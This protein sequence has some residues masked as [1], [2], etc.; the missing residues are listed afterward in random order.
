MRFLIRVSPSMVPRE[1]LYQTVRSVARALGLDPRDPKWTS[2]GALE[3]DVFAPTR[4]DFDLFVSAVEPLATF[5][6]TKDLNFPPP[7]KAEAELLAEARELFNAERYWEC[8]EVL[9]GVWRV[10][11][12]KEKSLLQGLILVCAAFVHSQKGEDNVALGVLRRSVPQL[13]YPG[14]HF[15]GIDLELLRHNVRTMLETSNFTNFTL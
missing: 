5:E 3:L 14:P 1:R 13:E 7:H 2:Y 4:V 10:K 12:G 9:E 6:F 8:H 15:G 11:Q